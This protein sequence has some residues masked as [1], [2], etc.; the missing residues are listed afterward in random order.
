MRFT[1]V[2]APT[3]PRNRQTGR[4]VNYEDTEYC[5]KTIL[6]D[7]CNTCQSVISNMDLSRLFAAI[8]VILVMVVRAHSLAAD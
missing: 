1:N 7:K 4:E 6:L 8:L 2:I 5:I 3:K